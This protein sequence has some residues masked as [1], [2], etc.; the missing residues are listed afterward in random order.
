MRNCKLNGLPFLTGLR[1]PSFPL[2]YLFVWDG[3]PLSSH[4]KLWEV[5]K[6]D[7]GVHVERVG[8]KGVN[9]INK[10]K[11]YTVL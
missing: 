9:G 6:S 4:Y 8:V 2:S 5:C 1:P 3:R 7:V 11:T 10:T